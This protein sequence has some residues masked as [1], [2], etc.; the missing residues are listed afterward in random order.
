VLGKAGGPGHEGG[1]PS[2]FAGTKGRDDP[3]LRGGQTV[4]GG[5]QDHV[6]QFAQHLVAPRH[7]KLAG[8]EAMIDDKLNA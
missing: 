5:Q 3:F 1:S 4:P 7:G 6:E 8:R 2:G